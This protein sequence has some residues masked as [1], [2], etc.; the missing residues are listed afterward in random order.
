MNIQQKLSLAL[1][2]HRAGSLDN[3][4]EGY[5]QVLKDY[6][7]H[8]DALHLLGMIHH[9]REDHEEAARLIEKAIA[10]NPNSPQYHFNLGT[11]LANLGRMKEAADAFQR[12]S[13]LDPKN[14][15][16]FGNLGNALRR[17]GKATEAVA[18][19]RR[20][21][22][23]KPNYVDALMTL[24][25]A[26]TDLGQ[27]DESISV[28]RQAMAIQPDSAVIRNNLGV[29]L[30]MWGDADG[31]IAEF[32]KAIQLDPNKPEC[33]SNM[34]NALRD[35]GKLDEAIA[36][37]RQAITLRPDYADAHCNLGQ[38][39]AA[40]GRLEWS[41]DVCR[42]ACKLR[43]DDPVQASNLL[44][45]LQFSPSYSWAS[46]LDE[47]K[48]W[49]RR[50]AD[51]LKRAIRPH[52]NVRSAG[53][54]LRV[55][56]LSPNFCL[57]CQSLFTSP[58]LKHHDRDQLEVFCYSDTARS[59]AVT[60]EL[61]SHVDHW[62]PL[63]GMIA[64]ELADLIRGD[65]IDIL[66]DLTMHMG[67]GRLLMMGLKPAPVQV[68][69]LA[70]PGTTGLGTMDYR[71]TDP[72][73]DPSGRHDQ[74]YTEQSV[75]L[76]DTFWCFD[77]HG[78]QTKVL[79]DVGP[80]PAEKNAYITFGSLNHLRKTNSGVMALWGR[81]MQATPGSRLL[82]LAPVGDARRWVLECLKEHGIDADRVQFIARQPHDAYLNEFNRIDICLDTLPYNGHTT[83]L[84]SMWMG[85]PVITQIGPTVVGRAG[86]SQLSNLGLTELA[87]DNDQGFVD[88]ATALAGD[89]SRLAELRRTL[90]ERMSQSPLMDAKRF[91]RSME[92]SFRSMWEKWLGSSGG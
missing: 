90:R 64:P 41:I 26:L 68:T 55:G 92:Q 78:M 62:R 11:S 52:E 61:K 49:G 27:R 33:F 56:Y 16:A 73:L 82:L 86:W 63:G 30:S 31:A 17:M 51:P 21:V 23:L 77:P 87:A 67:G 91:A 89:V 37:C 65:R 72:Y 46:I 19:C 5:R 57:H 48:E 28:L 22:K 81:V 71:L 2:H 24:G 75:R 70:Y 80:L 38:F 45:N 36:A 58:L 3:A 66:V 53:R 47:H 83:S 13:Q 25:N 76:A 34:G 8:P 1:Q 7:D 29:A 74:R 18:A 85:V 15:L 84:D 12:A 35:K 88:I 54:R 43:P 9:Q 79:P 4:A 32:E 6:P 59:D 40:V 20:A 39:L 14:A 44:F 10:A 60:D 42:R 69:W 50:F